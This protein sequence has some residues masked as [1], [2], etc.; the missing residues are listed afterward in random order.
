MTYRR[1]R[2]LPFALRKSPHSQL[3]HPEQRLGQ[4]LPLH[5]APC[6]ADVNARFLGQHLDLRRG[7]VGQ[8][9]V[10]SERQTDLGIVLENEGVIGGA[11]GSPEVKGL[12]RGVLLFP[13]I[14]DM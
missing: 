9:V 13:G 2:L 11:G 7:E 8:M 10:A 12:N 4:I 5:W 14:S 1:Q 3:E 6:T